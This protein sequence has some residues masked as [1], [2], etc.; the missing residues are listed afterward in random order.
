MKYTD[1]I[2]SHIITDYTAN[3]ENTPEH[4]FSL[5][6]M[7]PRKTQVRENLYPRIWHT[8]S[9]NKKSLISESKLKGR[10]LKEA[11]N[12][13]NNLKFWSRGK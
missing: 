4:G 3:T 13:V 5:T 2:K 12:T 7:F 1:Q 9:H 8:V 11:V 10:E 6:H